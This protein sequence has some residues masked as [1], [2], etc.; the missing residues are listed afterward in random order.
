M[1]SAHP[2]LRLQRAKTGTQRCR[3]RVHRDEM[4]MDWTSDRIDDWVFVDE[5]F[6]RG[7]VV[8]G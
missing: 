6:D 5:P 3:E 2:D 8:A 1:V 4:G 7:C